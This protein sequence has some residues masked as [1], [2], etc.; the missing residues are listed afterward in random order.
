MHHSIDIVDISGGWQQHQIQYHLR[1][2]LFYSYFSSRGNL[3]WID[4]LFYLGPT[5]MGW[6]TVPINHTHMEFMDSIQRVAD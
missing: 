3:Q 2:D 4:H 5:L 1:S 6:A